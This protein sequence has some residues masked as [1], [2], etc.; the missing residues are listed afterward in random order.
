MTMTLT[1]WEG[2]GA[3]ESARSLTDEAAQLLKLWLSLSGET[4][5]AST[6]AA[7]RY[8][9]KALPLKHR[10]WGR[11]RGGMVRERGRSGHLWISEVRRTAHQVWS[12]VPLDS[13]RGR[14]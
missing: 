12:G 6:T 4:E 9:T 14:E 13:W 1:M 2:G 3:G 11:Q 7:E 10:P 8:K 5:D